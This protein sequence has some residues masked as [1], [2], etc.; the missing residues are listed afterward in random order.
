[1]LAGI[2]KGGYN[3]GPVMHPHFFEDVVQVCLDGRFADVHR[4]RDAFIGQAK[5]EVIDDFLFPFRK[6]ALQHRKL[7]VQV[8]QGGR[9]APYKFVKQLPFSPYISRM[10]GLYSLYQ[11]T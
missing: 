4:M 1:M 3:L 2:D 9:G 6:G 7:R 10:N 5:K 8:R 11:L